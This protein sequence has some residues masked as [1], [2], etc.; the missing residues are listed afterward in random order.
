MLK[1]AFKKYFRYIIKR[2][3][4]IEPDEQVSTLGKVISAAV[5]SPQVVLEPFFSKIFGFDSS[6]FKD[7]VGAEYETRLKL[8]SQLTNEGTFKVNFDLLTIATNRALAGMQLKQG[9]FTPYSAADA[10][11]A[12]PTETSSGYPK[13]KRPKSLLKPEIL[14][15]MTKIINE[16]KFDLISTSHVCYESWR[17]QERQSG[18]KFRIFLIFPMLTN[19]FEMMFM[20]PILDYYRTY[21]YVRTP[22]LSYSFHSDFSEMATIWNNCQQYKTIIGIDYAQFDASI[23]QKMLIYCIRVIKS[24]FTMNFWQAAIFDQ[25]VMIHSHSLVITSDNGIP[26][27]YTKKSGILSGSVF[28]NFL[29]TLVNAIM[30]EY[31]LLKQGVK[32]R[33]VF[34]KFKG[35]DT[36][37]ATSENFNIS[38]FIQQLKY[39]FGANI[40]PEACQIFKPGD[41]I[42]YLGYFFTNNYKYASTTDLLRR[43]MTI[44]GR[45]IPEDVI[46]NNLR[47]LSKAVSILSNV[48]NGYDIFFNEIWDKLRTVYSMENLPEYYYDLTEREKGVTYAKRPIIHDLKNG[49][50]T[51]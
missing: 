34:K 18:T 7:P 51:K 16:S 12:L 5:R 11:D 27:F 43:K 45:F 14:A 41:A 50:A 47:V 26:S 20:G 42:F 25:L 8:R 31:G 29:G 30:V 33:K 35:D 2:N 36:I 10:V 46:P 23:S 22:A 9:M 37:I 38:I 13:F 21:E 17:T 4:F 48:T 28:T 39:S 40:E 3:P 49:W 6:N 24:T 44:S 15:Q 19:A 1:S 32:P